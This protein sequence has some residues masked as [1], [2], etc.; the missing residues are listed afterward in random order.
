MDTLDTG[1]TFY[2]GDS[3]KW[4]GE[5]FMRALKNGENISPALLRTADTLRTREWIAYDEALVAEAQIRL[6]GVADLMAAGLTKPIA[7][8]MGKTYL[9]Y[10]KVGDIDPAIV[11]LDGVTRSE[12]DTPEYSTANLPL[13]ITHKDFYINMRKLVASRNLGESLDVTMARASGRKVSEELERMLYQGGKTFGGST[14]Y[15][16][17]T[18]PNRNTMSFGT[19]GNWAQAAKTGADMLKD[20]Q[21]ALTLL[22]GDRMYGPYWVYVS[23]SGS[24]KLSDDFKA[25]SDKTI[26]ARLLEIDGIQR[27][28]VADQM[29]ANTVVVQASPDVVELVIGEPLQTVQWDVH[30]G[31][32][33]NFKAFQ[34]MVP[35]VKA[36]ASN[37]SGV[38]HIS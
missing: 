16:Y 11:S 37:R 36:D 24:I 25:A 35:L 33:I 30:G 34:I 9:E 15:G 2:A 13:P 12:N 4:A 3:G 31:M 20:V 32:Q 10:Q 8:A 19:N 23:S 7:N 26:R 18:H 14:I 17:C 29:P 22:E 38:V 21:D 5:Q 27:V 6:R 1:R 28:T